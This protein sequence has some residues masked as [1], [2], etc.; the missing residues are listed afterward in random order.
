MTMQERFKL[1]GSR[2][3]MRWSSTGIGADLLDPFIKLS[4]KP[5]GGAKPEIGVT[6]ADAPRTRASGFDACK[7]S[8]I[9]AP[10]LDRRTTQIPS[11]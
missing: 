4:T 7:T 1:S 10:S 9:G 8:M 3:S 5:G 6:N 2:Y 11:C